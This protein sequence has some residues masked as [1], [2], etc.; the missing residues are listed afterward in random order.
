MALGSSSDT[1][2][3]NSIRSSLAIRPPARVNCGTKRAEN[4]PHQGFSQW[5]QGDGNATCSSHGPARRLY[6]SWP[7]GSGEGRTCQNENPTTLGALGRCVSGT[8]TG[9]CPD[10]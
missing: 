8:R 7:K 2:P 6:L 5:T 4:G 1:T 9:P 10:A 3:L